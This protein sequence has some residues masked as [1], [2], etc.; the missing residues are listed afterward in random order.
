MFAHFADGTVAAS[1]D[2]SGAQK[3]IFGLAF[4][5]AVN[6]L[7]A[8]QI[9]VM[10]LDEPTA[11][12]D[13]QNTERMADVFAGLGRAAKARGQQIIVITHEELLYPVFNQV[14][15]LDGGQYDSRA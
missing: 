3:M 4:R 5:F 13:A 8:G 15:R 6:S 10:V 11:A 2:L 14:I 9:G 7:F 1:A 12:L